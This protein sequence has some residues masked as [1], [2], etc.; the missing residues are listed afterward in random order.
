MTEFNFRDMLKPGDA[1]RIALER[2]L[3]RRRDAWDKPGFHYRGGGDFLLQHGHFYQGRELPEE[4]AHWRGPLNQCF[5][6]ALRAAD[7]DPA[8][9]YC[10]GVY[11]VQNHY[12]PHA[13]CV[14]VEGQV[15][16]LT[17]PTDPEE[18]KISLD[19]ITNM[20]FQPP[21]YWGYWGVVFPELSFV[22]QHADALGLPMMDRPTVDRE[23][24]S[25]K[26]DLSDAEDFPLLR[27]PFDPQRKV[28]P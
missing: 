16:E 26:L 28:L 23:Y 11:A 22:R 18:L 7:S 19:Y 14:D 10:E 13:W 25:G 2:E 4:F 21:D 27:H 5:M 3:H 9:S 24:A 1:S 17:F 20:S 15:V 6:N 8:L 12:T